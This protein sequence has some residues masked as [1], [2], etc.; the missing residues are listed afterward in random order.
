MKGEKEFF[1]STK[2][3]FF[4]F[5][6]LRKKLNIMIKLFIEQ[7]SN[8]LGFSLDNTLFKNSQILKVACVFFDKTSYFTNFLLFHKV[9]YPFFVFMCTSFAYFYFESIK[10]IV[11]MVNL[12]G[13]SN[14]LSILSE[15]SF[16]FQLSLLLFFLFYQVVSVN[17]ILAY[18]EKISEFMKTKYQDNERLK[19]LHY[20]SGLSSFLRSSAPLAAAVSVFLGMEALETHKVQVGFETWGKVAQTAAENGQPIPD[21][22]VKITVLTHN[23]N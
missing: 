10:H 1:F 23:K 17:T 8:S 21:C 15:L 2:C 7:K 12:Y 9:G 13:I 19:K 11:L 20:N 18:S 22:P 14:F 4:L 5:V 16:D 6:I 3:E